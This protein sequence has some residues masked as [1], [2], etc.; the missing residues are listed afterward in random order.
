VRSNDT[1]FPDA[2]ETLTIV[3]VTDP[4]HGTTITSGATVLYTPDPSYVGADSFSYT[5]HDGNGGTDSA[6]VSINVHQGIVTGAGIWISNAELMALPTSGVPWNTLV[7]AANSTANSPKLSNQDDNTDVLTLAKA[8]V[9]V[10]LGNQQ[11]IAQARAN[12]MAAIGTE[13][14]GRTLALGRNLASFVIAADLVGLSPQ[15]DAT[16]RGWLRGVLSENLG[17][18]TLQSTHEDRPNNWGTMAGASRAAAAA[19]LGDQVELARTALVFK[20]YLGDRAAYSGFDYGSDLSWQAAP[21][22]PVGINP[23][24]ATKDGRS[25]DGVLPDDMRRG[26][27]FTWPPAQTGYP[28]E[29]LQG[30]LVQAEILHRA[31][32]DAWQ[33][34]D[35]ALLRA[36][37]FLNGIT[38]TAQGD[39]EWQ[40]WLVNAR[41]GSDFA[42]NPAARHGKIMGWTAWTHGSSTAPS[43]APMTTGT[44][45]LGT[46]PANSAKSND[47]DSSASSQLSPQPQAFQFGTFAY[48]PDPDDQPDPD[49]MYS[50]SEELNTPQGTDEDAQLLSAVDQAFA[51]WL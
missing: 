31:G 20:G 34:Q 6:T 5:I 25:I 38:W 50:S 13:D 40:P 11:L 28:W 14:G 4:P 41:Y 42:A 3:S 8:L 10:R 33:W 15:D 43:G 35:K 2:G 30:A 48:V 49:F 9:G 37:G 32:Y 12:I 24:G 23:M 21:S 36:V 26:G 44:E 22:R 45:S 46:M 19:Y 27:S 51:E 18:R 29:A 16:F 39:D 1:A 7:T 17:G 47:D